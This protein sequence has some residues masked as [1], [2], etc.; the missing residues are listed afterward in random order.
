MR[1]RKIKLLSVLLIG[2]FIVAGVVPALNID[3]ISSGKNPDVWVN[4]LSPNGGETW[5]GVETIIWDYSLLYGCYCYFFK[6]YCI[7]DQQY[8]LATHCEDDSFIFDTCCLPDGN[9]VVKVELW[10][11]SDWECQD[12]PSLVSE[13]TSDG[14]FTIDNGNHPEAN[15]TWEADGLTVTFTDIST[16]DGEITYRAWDFT[17]DG[18]FDDY[19]IVVTHTYPSSGTYSVLLLVQNDVAE[20]DHI[21]K[22]INLT[23]DKKPDLYCDGSLSWRNKPGTL[24]TGSF[25]V[26]NI[27]E[28]GSE[29]GWEVDSHPNWGNWNFTPPDGNGLKPSDGTVTVNVFVETPDVENA[30]FEGEVRIVNKEDSSDYCTIS[31]TMTTPKNKSI[32]TLFLSF[33]D[34]H[35]HLFPLLKQI[36][37]L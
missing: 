14:W 26:S 21:R 31:V 33:L 15:F 11:H 35:P 23:V 16:D 19:G 29:L 27:G 17:D 32:N 12:N 24:V 18:Y 4:V 2:L 36:L 28:L 30:F 9:Y 3:V 37:G 5:S 1:L 6:I 13:D 25:T 10:C 8:T 20:T 22:F 34:N 7:G